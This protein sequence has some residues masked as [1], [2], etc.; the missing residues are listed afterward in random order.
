MGWPGTATVDFNH[1]NLATFSGTA[2]V[3]VDGTSLTANDALGTR[4]VT[5]SDGAFVNVVDS[6]AKS[7]AL[8]I[9]GDL[10][11]DGRPPTFGS[12]EPFNI[13]VARLWIANSASNC[14]MPRLAEFNSSNWALV[15]PSLAPSSTRRW[16]RQV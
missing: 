13:S 6:A 9:V 2:S 5:V 4:A 16:R 11:L 1:D 3:T 14:L 8:N 12:V 7:N 10:H 15:K